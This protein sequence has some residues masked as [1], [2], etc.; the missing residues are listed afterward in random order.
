MFILIY[1][2]IIIG[3]LVFFIVTFIYLHICFHFKTSNDLEIFVIDESNQS[4]LQFEN[5]CDL[6]QPIIM[7][8]YDEHLKNILDISNLEQQ[9]HGYDLNVRN[10]V[11][12]INDYTYLPIKYKEVNKLLKNDEEKKYISENNTDF[13]KETGLI[14]E[15][16]NNDRFLRPEFSLY[17][18]YDLLYGSKNCK[19]PFRY[20][21]NYRNFFWV[22]SGKAIVK[23]CPPKYS[24]YLHEVTDYDNFEFRSKID[25]WNV[26]DQFKSDFDK[27]K[28][29]EI[30]VNEHSLIYIPAYWW[31]SIHFVENET[32][33]LVFKYRTIMNFLSVSNYLMIGWLQSNNVQEKIIKNTNEIIESERKETDL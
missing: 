25:C 5:M 24:K 11:E 30:E 31:Y 33:F 26:Q 3:T 28:T 12:N 8:Y 14:H 9:Y 27:V 32:K 22:T 19:T 17:N 23:M 18:N 1:M 13:I 29:I 7:T 6:R 21:I 2:K 10:T 4:K 15:L 16:N 20:E